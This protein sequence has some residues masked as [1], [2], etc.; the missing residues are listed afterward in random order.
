MSNDLIQN[1]KTDSRLEAQE[2]QSLV[3]LALGN[4]NLYDFILKLDRAAH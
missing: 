1:M 3:P 4:V 2:R